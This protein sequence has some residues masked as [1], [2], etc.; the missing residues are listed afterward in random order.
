MLDL[1][2][3]GGLA[4]RVLYAS[5]ARPSGVIVMAPGGSGDVGVE[6][7]GDLRHD[8]NFVVRT[9]SLWVARGYAVLIPDALDHENMRGLRSSPAYGALIDGLVGFARSKVSGPVFLLGTSQG[10]IAAMNGA[11]HAHPGQLAGVVLTE[12]VSRMGGSHETVFDAD[13]QDVRVPALVV[14]NR[15]DACNV[16]P[17]EDAPRIAQAMSHSRGVRVMYVSGGTTKSR[18]AC[19]SLTPHG[20]YGIE[21]QVVGQIAD[22]M[23]AHR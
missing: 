1:P 10:S 15:D 11:A 23:D 20:Y 6:R 5:P 2:L 19:G 7:D 3:G 13:P 14:A 18:K 12:S 16:A 22:W 17:P 21:T 9:R 4:Q 8:D